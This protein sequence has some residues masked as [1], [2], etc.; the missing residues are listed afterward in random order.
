MS[1]HSK[2]H[3]VKHQKAAKDP[4]KSK[5]FSLHARLIQVAVKSGGPDPDMNPALR[6]AIDDAKAI[7]LPKENIQRAINKGAGIG[8]EGAM[9]TFTLEGYGP[10]GVAVMLTVTTDNRN[11][12]VAEVRK[13]FKDSGGS[14]GEPGSA[15]F[16]FGSDPDNPQYK[17]PISDAHQLQQFEDLVDELDSNEDVDD[18]V[19][20]LG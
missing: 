20:N 6:K 7:N 14:L 2:W 5:A 9:E 15:A 4:K 11:R 18:L 16:V 19:H 13:A 3:K 10:G 8:N 1:G 17:T 12:T